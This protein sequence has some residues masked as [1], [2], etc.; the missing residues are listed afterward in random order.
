[1]T[2][3]KNSWTTGNLKWQ[4]LEIATVNWPLYGN[5]WDFEMT[6]VKNS[7]T[8]EILKWQ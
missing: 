4:C 7:W 5:S 1:M 3:V 8:A 6:S 2:S